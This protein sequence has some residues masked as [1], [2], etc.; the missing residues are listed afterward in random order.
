MDHPI[1]LVNYCLNIDQLPDDFAEQYVFETVAD[2]KSG[3][4]RLAA[5]EW[6]AVLA[7]AELPDMRGLD[8]LARATA[9]SDAVQIGRAS[10]RERV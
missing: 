10:C 5:G 2:G 8:F 4:A 3:L 7:A 9:C 1:L 6:R